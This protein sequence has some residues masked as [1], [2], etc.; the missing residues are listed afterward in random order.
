MDEKETFKKNRE[1][2]IY[3]ICYFLGDYTRFLSNWY[4]M[5]SS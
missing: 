1:L 3:K 5:C 2:P 4:T